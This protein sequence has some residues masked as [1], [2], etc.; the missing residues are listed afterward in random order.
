MYRV[1]KGGACTR[2]ATPS[3]NDSTMMTRVLIAG[4]RIII[5]ACSSWS[6]EGD[7]EEQWD[8]RGERLSIY[9][10]ENK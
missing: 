8:V 2:V 9:V 10:L 6:D 3:L 7:V 1:K 5:S 4:A